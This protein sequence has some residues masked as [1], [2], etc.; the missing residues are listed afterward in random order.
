[1]SNRTSTEIPHKNYKYLLSL[2]ITGV[3]PQSVI[4]VDNIKQICEKY[5]KGRY[6]LEIIDVY[7]QPGLAADVQIIVAPTLIKTAPLPQKK[8]IGDMSDTKA[9]LIGLGIHSEI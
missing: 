3:N 1:M 4:A 2:Y 7:Q 8:L 5:L 9:V 6:E